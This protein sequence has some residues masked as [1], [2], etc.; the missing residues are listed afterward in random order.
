MPRQRSVAGTRSLR[1]MGRETPNTSAMMRVAWR[2]MRSCDDIRG[3][4]ATDT[5]SRLTLTVALLPAC[6]PLRPRPKT[7]E[8]RR[9]ALAR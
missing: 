9:H 6:G 4:S 7:F 8:R 1:H 3:H 2:A 5:P